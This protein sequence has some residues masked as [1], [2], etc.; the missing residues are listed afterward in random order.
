MEPNFTSFGLVDEAL[1]ECFLMGAHICNPQELAFACMN[2]EG[3]NIAFPANTWLHSGEVAV[4]AFQVSNSTYVAYS[5][6]RMANDKCFGPNALNSPSATTS[7]DLY[8]T[9]RNY[10]CCIDH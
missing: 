4:Q 10:A 6:Y 9:K 2:R 5:I 7:Y 8:G 3:Y 1:Q